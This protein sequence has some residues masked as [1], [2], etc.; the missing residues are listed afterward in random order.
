MATAAETERENIEVKLD[1]ALLFVQGCKDLPTIHQIMNVLEITTSSGLDKN[2]R[3][4]VVRALIGYLNDQTL[5]TVVDDLEIKLDMINNLC[6]NYYARKRES[7]REDAQRDVNVRMRTTDRV[8]LPEMR[9]HNTGLIGAT[10]ATPTT[11]DLLGDGEVLREEERQQTPA[12]RPMPVLDR[13]RRPPQLPQ[14]VV[15]RGLDVNRVGAPDDNVFVDQVVDGHDLVQNFNLGIYDNLDNQFPIVDEIPQDVINNLP[16]IPGNNGVPVFDRVRPAGHHPNG[17]HL[18][19]FVVE[20]VRPVVRPPQNA[21]FAAARFAAPVPQNVGLGA[22]RFVA[23]APR[24]VNHPFVRSPAPVNQNVHPAPVPVYRPNVPAVP[25]PAHVPVFPAPVHAPAA[26]APVH[27]PYVQQPAPVQIPAPAPVQYPVQV[28]APAPVAPAGY[29]GGG[30][31]R[32]CKIT[33]KI[34]DPGEKDG[35]TY[36]SLMFQIES[37]VRQ[38]YPEVDI[39]AAII[40]ATSSS[41]LRGVLE[42]TAAATIADITPALKAHFTVRG[43]KSV[44]NELGREKQGSKETALKFCQRMIGLRHLVTRMNEEENGEYTGELIQSQFQYSLSTGLRGELRHVLRGILR[45]PNVPDNVLMKEI[46]DLMLNEA[47]HEEKEGGQKAKVNFLE[48]EEQSTIKEQKKE[49]KVMKN[50][51][52]KISAEMKNVTALNNRVDELT[53][54]LK[55][56]Q[57]AFGS[58]QLTPEQKLLLTSEHPGMIPAAN[59]NV[60]PTV[61]TAVNYNIPPT[62]PTAVPPPMFQLQIPIAGMTRIFRMVTDSILFL[63]STGEVFKVVDT[64]EGVHKIIDHVEVIVVDIVEDLIVF[65]VVQVM[66]VV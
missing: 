35:I 32:E 4:A 44:F 16:D 38:R 45:V 31:F 6:S 40:R 8:D 58:I 19:P 24:L 26:L 20:N 15:D 62:V 55:M 52:S 12:E 14:M 37:A 27:Y 22:A 51:L 11:A 13:P 53:K 63:Q 59:H 54:E 7:R 3:R 17:A 50:E 56:Q 25:A 42:A 39:V 21:G 23:P 30:R 33:G 2:D 61:P 10:A 47:E 18:A 29:Y 49:Q 46:T 65:G 64:L 1:R 66:V 48:T 9:P 60:P 34:V 5:F 41:S 43:V 57:R 36:G 28:P